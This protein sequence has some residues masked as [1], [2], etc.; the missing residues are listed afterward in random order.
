LFDFALWLAVILCFAAVSV[1]LFCFALRSYLVNIFFPFFLCFLTF[2]DMFNIEKQFLQ[3]PDQWNE[4][5]CMYVYTLMYVSMFVCIH[6]IC[7]Y[8]C[9]KVGIY[10]YIV[11]VYIIYNYAYMCLWMCICVCYIRMY[12]FMCVFICVYNLVYM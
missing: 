11:Y 5:V 9:M 1:F 6:N 4:C 3:R 12:T 2:V 7:M 10:L 8:A